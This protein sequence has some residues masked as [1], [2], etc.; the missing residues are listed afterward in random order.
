MSE[1]RKQGYGICAKQSEQTEV[2]ESEWSSERTERPGAPPF[3]FGVASLH[4]GE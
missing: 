4:G 2:C 3:R 1:D